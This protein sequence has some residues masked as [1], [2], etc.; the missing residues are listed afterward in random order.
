MASR[1][2]RL[3]LCFS[4]RQAFSDALCA[5]R[6]H[7]AIKINEL[8]RSVFGVIGLSPLYVKNNRSSIRHRKVCLITTYYKTI[9]SLFCTNIFH[10]NLRMI[11]RESLTISKFF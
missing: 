4:V 10:I 9:I 11:R 3:R 1:F 2:R 5:R 7:T 8:N 6:N